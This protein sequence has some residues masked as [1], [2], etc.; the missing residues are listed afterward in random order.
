MLSHGEWAI[1][2]ASSDYSEY[3]DINNQDQAGAHY[4]TYMTG[5]GGN[6]PDQSEYATVAAVA[7]GGK[8]VT[9]SSPL[10]YLHWGVWPETAEVGLLTRNIVVRDDEA[11]ANTFFGGHFI[12]RSEFVSP[13]PFGM[14]IGDGSEQGNI[15]D[16]NLVIW[17][18]PMND[19]YLLVPSDNRPSSVWITNPN[20]TFTNNAVSSAYIGY[21]WV[22]PT[23]PKGLSAVEYA[24]VNLFPR[25]IACHLFDNN[26]AHSIF[27]FGLMIDDMATPDDQLESTAWMPQQPPYEYYHDAINVEMSRFTAWRTRKGGTERIREWQ[28][29]VEFESLVLSHGERSQQVTVNMDQVTE[30]KEDEFILTRLYGQSLIDTLLVG[31]SHLHRTNGFLIDRSTNVI[32]EST[33]VSLETGVV[34]RQT[35]F[36]AGVHLSQ[37]VSDSIWTDEGLRFPV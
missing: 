10:R 7:D 37:S 5:Q 24:N 22:M 36:V 9:L 11:S 26:I 16:S 33:D 20:N 3:F 8:T 13:I 25:R 31:R 35:A 23:K 2:I 4:Q 30:M 28:H 6:F 12:T 18:R 1:T 21:W 29:S 15:L 32:R 34:S 27:F 17:S 14:R 19:S